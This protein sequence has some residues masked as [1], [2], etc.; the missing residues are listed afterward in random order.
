VHHNAGPGVWGDIDALDTLYENNTV[1]ENWGPG[2]FHEISHRAIIRNNIVV[3]NGRPVDKG[4]GWLWDAQIQVS[5][6]QDVEIYGN[7]IEADSTLSSHGIVFSQQRRGVGPYGEYRVANNYV[8]DNDI[9]VTGSGPYGLSG[10]VADYNGPAMFGR[11]AGNRFDG[12]RYHVPVLN[13]AFWAWNEKAQTF[14]GFRAE[15][16]ESRGSVDTNVV[17][18]PVPRPPRARGSP[19][20]PDRAR[21]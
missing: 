3:R 4:S 9:T 15:G 12:N 19:E 1:V 11:S 5:T 16:H 18:W 20:S 14:A 2:I 13:R 17:P 6:S 10:A 7:R 21:R 8:H